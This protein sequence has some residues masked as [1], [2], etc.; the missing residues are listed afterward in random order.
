MEGVITVGI[1]AFIFSMGF[2]FFC[3]VEK[4][5]EKAVARKNMRS[6]LE[7]QPIEKISIK[8]VNE[9]INIK[10]LNNIKSD[11]SCVICMENEK[12]IVFLPCGHI[13]S[14]FS[15]ASSLHSCPLCR[16]KISQ[17]HK[18]FF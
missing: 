14:C 2:S 10:H 3:Y 8:T 15:C 7:R 13:A 18:V 5:I 17:Q 9:K 6:Y 11:N 12:N 4:K 1:I 16:V